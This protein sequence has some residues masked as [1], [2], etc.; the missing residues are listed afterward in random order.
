MYSPGV[1]MMRIRIELH[2]YR[3]F[4]EIYLSMVTGGSPRGIYR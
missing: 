4:Q 1:G 3:F 2:L